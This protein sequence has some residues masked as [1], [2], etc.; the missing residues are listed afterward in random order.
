MTVSH[1]S[2]TT[3]I[4]DYTHTDTDNISDPTD[5]K[6]YII[7]NSYA[8]GSGNNQMQDMFRIEVTISPGGDNED[9]YDLAGG[10]VDAFGNTLTFAT[11][12]K[13]IL[14][15][16]A[17]VSGDDL[18]LGGLVSGTT[19]SLI[20]DLFGAVDGGVTVKAGGS[21]NIEAPLT[22]YTVTGGSAD[23]LAISNDGV[24]DVTY[25]LLIGGTR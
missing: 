10:V 1:T 8:D 11:I 13:L 12:K 21:V 16:T 9:S 20:T 14:L 4:W 25:Q 7:S 5:K 15:N 22:G 3:T 19:G 23:I 24:N 17:T 2:K 18:R 6:L